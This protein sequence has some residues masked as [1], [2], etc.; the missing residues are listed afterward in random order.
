MALFA[1]LLP[2]PRAVAAAAVSPARA[3][4]SSCRVTSLVLRF[5]VSLFIG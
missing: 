2:R 4:S 1:L 5:F 3:A